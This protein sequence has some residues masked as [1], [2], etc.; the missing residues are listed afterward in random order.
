VIVET[1]SAVPLEVPLREPFVIAS[2]RMD[3]TRAALICVTTESGVRGLGEAAPLPPVTA[4]DLPDVLAL[5]EAVRPS[6]AGAK[7]ESLEAI[8]PLLDPLLADHPVTRAAI[9]CAILD[10]FAR[11]RGV[12]LRHLFASDAIDALETDI[13][14][15]IHSPERMGELARE[16]RSEGFRAFKVKVGKDA[17]QD[18]RALAAI[19]ANAPDA[20]LRLDA[21]EGLS[22]DDALALL[23]SARALGVNVECFEQPCPRADLDAMAYVTARSSVPIVADESLRSL[24]DLES[25]VQRRAAHGVNL[26]LAK[27]GGP[28]AALEIGRRARAAGLRIMCGAMVETKLGLCAMAQV[29]SALGVDGRRPVASYVDWIDLDTAFLLTTDPFEGG[30]RARGPHLELLPLP[31]LGLTDAR[32]RLR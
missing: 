25:I 6:L 8:A 9:E 28:I 27:L 31:G 12:P 2:G 21:N 30:W 13:T 19:F 7:I 11:T 29:A 1:I 16:H 10:A 24:A 17:A 32:T 5:V 20:T 23:D 18:A 3:A 15:P 26:K 4:E 14:I 22:P